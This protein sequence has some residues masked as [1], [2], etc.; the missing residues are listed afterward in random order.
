MPTPLD[1]IWLTPQ[2]SV[3]S[4]SH[5]SILY[6]KHVSTVKMCLA[7]TKHQEIT[8]DYQR[9]SDRTKDEAGCPLFVD[10]TVHRMG[11]FK[12]GQAVV[13]CIRAFESFLSNRSL[14]VGW[15]LLKTRY[16]QLASAH[17]SRIKT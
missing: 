8:I 14:R 9:C 1:V 6:S 10:A 7:W 16:R 12:R 15:L 13:P 2:T 11:L 4:T 17:E 5:V 3:I